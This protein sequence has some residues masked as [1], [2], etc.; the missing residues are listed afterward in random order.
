MKTVQEAWTCEPDPGADRDRSTMNDARPLAPDLVVVAVVNGV[1]TI[2]EMEDR[3]G[4]TGKPAHGRRTPASSSSRPWARSCPRSRGPGGTSSST[5]V[6]GRGAA[7]HVAVAPRGV[8]E[9]IKMQD[10]PMQAPSRPDPWSDRRRGRQSRGKQPTS[11]GARP[12]R[13]T[14]TLQVKDARPRL[15]GGG[16]GGSV[17]ADLTVTVQRGYCGPND[18][19]AV[20]QAAASPPT[21][22]TSAA[23]GP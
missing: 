1:E 6:S 16:C 9:G 19:H 21:C 3:P 23:R 12:A 20:R 17:R 15:E 14:T 4:A 11:R 5:E 18:Q 7:E 2:S 22:S 13:G 10:S 8:A